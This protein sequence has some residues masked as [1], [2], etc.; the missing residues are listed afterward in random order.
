M[1]KTG[2]STILSAT[3]SKPCSHTDSSRVDT[4]GHRPAPKRI[5]PFAILRWTSLGG[6]ATGPMALRG[7]VMDNFPRA[8]PA[9]PSTVTGHDGTRQRVPLVTVQP[10][11]RRPACQTTHGSA[12]IPHSLKQDVMRR[13]RL[14]RVAVSV[15]AATH[16]GVPESA[17]SWPSGIRHPGRSLSS[18]PDWRPGMSGLWPF[19]LLCCRGPAPAVLV[20]RPW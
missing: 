13:A 3:K 14:A 5:S 6:A 15:P 20:L 1:T 16:P 19:G 8:A 2:P 9:G 11:K 4:R 7:A 10:A 18:R 12:V 17:V